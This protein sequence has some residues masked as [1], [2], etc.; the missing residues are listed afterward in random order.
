MH[1]VKDASTKAGGIQ[2]F[3]L[4]LCMTSIPKSRS[5]IY[6][7]KYCHFLKNSGYWSYSLMQCTCRYIQKNEFDLKKK[8][9]NLFVDLFR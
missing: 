5:F 4:L 3:V 8:Y 9:S 6:P 1:A 7:H 2:Q